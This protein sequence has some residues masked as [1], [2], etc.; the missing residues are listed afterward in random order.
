MPCPGELRLAVGVRGSL[1][2]RMT[3][4]TNGSAGRLTSVPT[5]TAGLSYLHVTSNF[6][7]AILH[8][9]R[10]SRAVPAS[11]THPFS[12]RI[13]VFY[14]LLAILSLGRRLSH[15]TAPPRLPPMLSST[16]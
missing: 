6:C 14:S 9:Q 13:V 12:Q 10:A 7:P 8:P 1:Q 15:D 4:G 3:K 5:Q 2:T 16:Q 11:H